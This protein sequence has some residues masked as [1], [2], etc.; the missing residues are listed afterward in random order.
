MKKFIL[1]IILFIIVYLTI[2][3]I[4]SVF[5]PY[6]WGNP[7][8]ST[9]IQYLE[10]ETDLPNTFFFGSSGVYR[11]I[12]PFIFDSVSKS[13]ATENII[14]YNLGSP[15]TFCPQTYFLYE[16]FLRSSVSKN[17]KYA[18]IELTDIDILHKELIHQERTT[19]WQNLHDV[20]FVF[21]SVFN[22]K[23]MRMPMKLKYVSSYI[24]SYLANI[25][26]VGHYGQEIFTA[27]YYDKNYLGRNKDGFFPL[28]HELLVTKNKVVKDHLYERQRSLKADSLSIIERAKESVKLF[29]KPTKD[30][31]VIHLNRIIELI[32]LSKK[33]GVTLFFLLGTKRSSQNLIN[34]YYSIPDANK[35]QLANANDYPE[36]YS[37]ESAFDQFHLNIKGAYFYSSDLAKE[38]YKKISK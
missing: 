36:L 28:E 24:L 9:K 32:E 17:A 30:I 7:W 15:A 19:Y 13:L 3:K 11:Q 22:N 4:I 27:N 21:T 10:K 29:S 25:F 16:E 26:H 37:Y 5:I 23:K 2:E 14:S 33:K 31:D 20:R 1:K 34:L 35:I 12:N 8:Y 6:H 18:F 38:F